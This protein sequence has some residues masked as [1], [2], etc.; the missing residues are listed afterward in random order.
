MSIE[1]QLIKV[2]ND[3]NP[4]NQNSKERLE[5]M[6]ALNGKY[7]VIFYNHDGIS[8]DI[9]PSEYLNSADALVLEEA[10][11]FKGMAKKKTSDQMI[12]KM[13]DPESPTCLLVKE[14]I[15]QCKPLFLADISRDTFKKISDEENKVMGLSVI[16]AVLATAATAGGISLMTTEGNRGMTRRDFLKKSFVAT[17]TA[18]TALGLAGPL[19]KEMT[20]TLNNKKLTEIYKAIDKIHPEMRTF[21]VDGRN[22]LIAQKSETIARILS[23]EKGAKPQIAACIGSAHYDFPKALLSD[24]NERITEL[25]KYEDMSPEKDSLIV[26]INF[27]PTSDPNARRYEIVLLED[28]KIKNMNIKG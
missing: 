19:L 5:S 16:E 10:N 1:D 18:A 28:E 21:T 3:P 13:I 23:K 9:I 26:R 22:N 11:L 20:T 8:K 12:N 4:D 6:E 24:E 27:H 17:A 2:F 25:E 15:R 14:A 7:S